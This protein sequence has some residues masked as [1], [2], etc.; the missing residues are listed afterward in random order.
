[1]RQGLE[2]KDRAEAAAKFNLDPTKRILFVMGGS[3][4]ARGI[5]E[6]VA[7]MLPMAEDRKGDWQFVHLTGPGNDQAVRDNY[8]R[9]G[10]TATVLP[11]CSEMEYL[12]SIAD[13]I[14]ARS[15]ASSLN[16]TAHYGIPSI[17]VPYP[18]AADDHQRLN[19]LIFERVGAAHMF[20]E[21]KLDPATL[22]KVI[23]EIFN[24]PETHRLMS[25]AARQLA[26]TNAASAVADVI[27]NACRK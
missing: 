5:N 21:D 4:G 19:A 22:K 14:I 26:G 27:E 6:A 20:A 8:Q 9:A 17:L 25:D 2:R 16:E 13:L 18:Y 10:F 23:E 1:M 11:F 7:K 12:Y 3:Q 24:E 15:G